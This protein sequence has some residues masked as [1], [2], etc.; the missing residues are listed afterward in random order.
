MPAEPELLEQLRFRQAVIDD[1][2]TLLQ[3]LADDDLGKNR[4]A[5]GSAD[6]VYQQAFAEI[7]ADK[8]QYLLVAELDGAVIAMLQLTF[9]PGLSRRG[10]WRALIEAVR[11][12]SHL[13]S[14]GIGHALMQQAIQLAQA[15]QCRLVQLTSDKQRQQAHKFY[16]ELGFVAS[17]VGFKRVL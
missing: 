16:T 8:N 14:R 3:L 5:V 11:V 6:P 10:A 9:I 12:A 17:H 13:R 1:L 7:S 4:E 2:P 15:R